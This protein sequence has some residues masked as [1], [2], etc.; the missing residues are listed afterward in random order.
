[1]DEAPRRLRVLAISGSLRRLS[2]N[3]ALIAAIAKIAPGDVDVVAYTDLA[4]IPPFNPDIA[5]ADAPPSV[6]ALRAAVTT[7][8]AVI[9]SSPE[10]AHG[11]PG[12]LK[13]ALDWLVGSGEFID[14]PVAVINASSRATH[15]RASLVETLIM[16]SASIVSEASITLPLDGRPADP[17]LLAA[18]AG[19]ARDIRAALVA[20][21]RKASDLRQRP[22]DIA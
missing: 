20:L 6:R 4:Q 21:G 9:I 19:I 12:V 17:P 1:M 18:D 8:D 2:T 5:D 10:Y 22:D 13:N 3:T 11:V 14:K 16:M 7:S 15:A